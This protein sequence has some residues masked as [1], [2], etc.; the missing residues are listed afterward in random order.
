MIL[1]SKSFLINISNDEFGFPK[2]GVGSG[3]GLS[4]FPY[5]I[6]SLTLYFFFLIGTCP[7]VGVTGHILCGGYGRLG[8]YTGLTSDQVLGFKVFFFF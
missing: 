7:T 1:L 3:G 5:D 8:R 2:F 4:L 6:S